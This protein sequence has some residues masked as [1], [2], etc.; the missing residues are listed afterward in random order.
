MEAVMRSNGQPA[1][2]VGELGDKTLLP[3]AYGGHCYYVRRCTTG[4]MVDGEFWRRQMGGVE[5]PESAITRSQVGEIIGRG[6]RVGRPCISRRHREHHKRAR[7]FSD[8]ANV[9]DFV[10]IP[11]E[12]DPG[13]KR[14]EL[15][16]AEF[17]IEESVP[18]AIY[19]F[20]GETDG[21]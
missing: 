5:I 19:S 14:S 2:G 18:L 16:N 9:G 6:P 12:D 10:L 8:G 20:D 17:F 3:L 1:V 11:S 13:I 15:G 7:W 21:N 4:E